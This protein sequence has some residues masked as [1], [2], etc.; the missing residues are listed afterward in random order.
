MNFSLFKKNY[1]CLVAGLSD[2]IINGNTLLENS[3]QFKEEL[4]EQLTT[5]DYK[6]AKLLYLP[7]D[8]TNLINL[9]LKQN[10][11]FSK[12]GNYT[13]AYLEEQIKE[14]T[15]IVGYIKQLILTFKSQPSKNTQL[16]TEKQL[17]SLYYEF[18]LQT[19]NSFLNH[20][21]KFDRDMKNILTAINCRKYGYNIEQ[22]LIPTKYKNEIYE[23]L[24][25]GNLTTELLTDEVPYAEKI[26]QIAE[27]E[28][29]I[30]EKEKALDTIKW[31]FLDQHTFFHY[32][33]IEKILSFIIKITIVERW[34][35][36]DAKTGKVLFEKLI[37]DIKT[38]YTFEEEFSL[39][40]KIK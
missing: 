3:I 4:A 21:F 8:N 13:K 30:T 29:N 31:K 26:V 15:N 9:L 38:S 18:A 40:R 19:E 25:S 39:K 36:L 12:L 24:I 1:Y 34:L 2:V 28:I 20:W 33:T 10:K 7:N 32:F 14:P 11:K 27:S 17:Q 22:Q 16:N 23:T 6:L 5:S 37:N 35:K